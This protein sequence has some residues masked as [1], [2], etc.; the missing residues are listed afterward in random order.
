LTLA[1]LDILNSSEGSAA[2]ASLAARNG[3]SRE[4]TDA[5]LETVVPALSQRIERNTLSRGGVADLVAELSHPEHA[6]AFGD[7]NFVTT[8]AAREAGIGALDTIFFGSKSQSRALAARAAAS[9]GVGQDLIAKL[10]P[11][12][13]SIVMGALANK[14]QGGLGDIIKKLPD[15]GGAGG[16]QPRT[17]REQAPTNDGGLGDILS[18]IPGM[19]GSTGSGQ[20]G[21]APTRGNSRPSPFPQSNDSNDPLPLPGDRIPGVNTPS[22]APE[23]SPYGDLPDIIRQGG[24]KVEGSALGTL[25]RS[26]LGSALGFQSKGIMGW[27]I[28]LIVM[29]WGWGFVQGILRRVLTGR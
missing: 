8:P 17:R 1:L 26:V 7:A 5:I 2:L 14:T 15:M 29:R 25:V 3:L 28:R 9:S 6:R 22:R 23:N 19:P 20:M 12:L 4:Q 13:A 27:I 18:K 24:Q 10:L 11:I 16:P 21:G